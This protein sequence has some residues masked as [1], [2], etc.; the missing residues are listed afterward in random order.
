M[1]ES[2]RLNELYSYNLLDTAPEEELDEL[3]KL[4][5]L[6]CGTPISLISMV[7][8]DRQW[9]KATYGLEITET[10][11][12]DSFCRYLLGN[13]IPL[14]EINDA[15]QDYR[16]EN[17]PLVLG[18]PHIRYYAGAPL[19]TSNGNILGA[20][21]FRHCCLLSHARFALDQTFLCTHNLAAM[22]NFLWIFSGSTRR[23]IGNKFSSLW[24]CHATVLASDCFT[25]TLKLANRCF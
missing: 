21:C 23:R 17:N 22:A 2:Q 20:L 7:D 5:S 13:D 3:A 19:K 10:P 24:T 25:N 1:D 8:K 12:E 16:F 4:A 9:F 15:L 11:R 14:L 18:H 6:I